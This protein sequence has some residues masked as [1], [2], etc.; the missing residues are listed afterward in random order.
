M[1]GH[2][3][4]FVIGILTSVIG[5]F[6]LSSLRPS[7]MDRSGL[8]RDFLLWAA[9][10]ICAVAVGILI[11][12]LSHRVFLPIINAF[13]SGGAEEIRPLAQVFSAVLSVCLG[14]IGS[15]GSFRLFWR[16]QSQ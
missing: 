15:I 7:R 3:V 2:G 10:S 12:L 4:E 13:V 6:I 5:G 14:V 16:H 1:E 9:L 11:G 8:G